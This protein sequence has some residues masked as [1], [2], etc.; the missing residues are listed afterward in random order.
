MTRQKRDYLWVGVFAVLVTFAIPWFLWRDATTWAGLPVWLWWHVGWMFLASG[1]FY[2]FTR[3][4]WDRGM[5]VD[6]EEV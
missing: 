5:S 2:L 6:A 4:A 3:G 1:A